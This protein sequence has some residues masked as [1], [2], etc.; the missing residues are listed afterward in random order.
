MEGLPK[1]FKGPLNW[2][3]YLR[4]FLVGNCSTWLS[5]GETN[6]SSTNKFSIV[7]ST[8]LIFGLAYASFRGRRGK[9]VSGLICSVRCISPICSLLSLL[10]SH[11]LPLMRPAFFEPVHMNWTSP[12]SIWEIILLPS[13]ASYTRD[14]PWQKTD[15]LIQ[16]VCPIFII[17]STHCI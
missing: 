9:G 12:D 15:S 14:S 5:L 10:K 8:V 16:A 4:V 6:L 1:K 13:L 17:V 2:R 3:K 11:I 7:Y